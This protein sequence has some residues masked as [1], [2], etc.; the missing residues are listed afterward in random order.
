MSSESAGFS[1]VSGEGGGS[2]GAVDFGALDVTFSAS[3][4]TGVFLSSRELQGNYEVHQ[5][6]VQVGLERKL[7]WGWKYPSYGDA[8]WQKTVSPVYFVGVELEDPL[9]VLSQNIVNRISTFKDNYEFDSIGVRI[10]FFEFGFGSVSIKFEGLSIKEGMMGSAEDLKK[11]LS[12]CEKAIKPTLDSVVVE[13]AEAYSCCVPCCIK[14]SDIWDINNFNGLEI[15]EGVNHGE[16][17]YKVGCIEVINIFAVLMR[18][19]QQNFDALALQLRKLFL[20]FSEELNDVPFNVE[21][22]LFK[23]GGNVVIALGKNTNGGINLVETDDMI[24]AM[25]VMTVGTGIARYFNNFFFSYFNY[26]SSEYEIIASRSLARY[27]HNYRLRNLIEK[28]SDVK[29]IYSQVYLQLKE[30]NGFCVDYRR[31]KLIQLLWKDLKVQEAW[32]KSD[33]SMK[34]L[35]EI[36][37]WLD[38]IRL[39]NIGLA[40]L[41]FVNIMLMLTI[42]VG[43]NATLALAIDIASNNNLEK[44][45]SSGLLILIF[46][47][48]IIYIFVHTWLGYITFSRH[49]RRKLHYICG[50]QKQNYKDAFKNQEM[51]NRDRKLCVCGVRICEVD[52][53]HRCYGNEWHKRVFYHKKNKCFRCARSHQN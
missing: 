43:I 23:S 50:L 21:Y 7:P 34:K 29:T 2:A 33:S 46:F 24:E 11:I 51:K 27:A 4:Y 26:A 28:F 47:S 6:I 42:L 22:T 52:D 1:T 36:N 10:K 38:K 44:Y 16:G 18:N 19:E 35:T 30:Y 49:I 25:E 32:H 5:R 15:T 14:N 40:N 3:F 17:I 39:S 53:C 45:I 9:A 12:V 20:C 8:H 37:N 48:L 31:T 13:V 41:S